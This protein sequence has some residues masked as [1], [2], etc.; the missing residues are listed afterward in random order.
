M[1]EILLLIYLSRR[2]SRKA[3][4]LGKSAKVYGFSTWAVWLIC[5]FLGAWM[6]AN[7]FPG[8]LPI[9]YILALVFAG[10]GYL[11][12]NATLSPNGGFIVSFLAVPLALYTVFLLIPNF[13]ILIF[14]FTR[15]SG[16]SSN[17]TFNGINNFIKLMDDEKFWNALAHNG[18]AMLV[19]PVVVI[20]ISLFFAFLFTQG[21]RYAKIFRTT[22]FFPQVLSV[23]IVGVLWGFVYH[24]TIGVLNSVL[25]TLGLDQFESFPWLGD[26]GTV[27]GSVLAVVI[28]QS[29]GF[30]MV[31]FVA[32]MQAIPQDYFEAARV[33]GASGW[34]VFWDITIPLLWDSIRTSIVYLA[35]GAMD[36]F[37]IVT[38]M[39]N[40]TGGPS[41]AADVASVYLYSKAFSEG[42]FGYATAMGLVLLVLVMGFS[43]ISLRIT[44]RESIEY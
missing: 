36:L 6:G 29:V 15:W 12:F 33:D 38:V 31:L 28:W 7:I 39:T 18:I 16:I 5:E 25:T 24:P 2:V 41:R 27:F 9:I 3:A 26:R 14:A 22:F 21:I 8:Q 37:A 17:I 10:G 11:L 32:A 1:I 42:Q 4:A 30:Y 40:G 20:S 19:L 34:N 23:V 13:S 43:I 44:A 35:I